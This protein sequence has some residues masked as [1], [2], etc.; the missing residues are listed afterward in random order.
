MKGLHK[1]IAWALALILAAPLP[2]GAQSAPPAQ[3]Q[4]QPPPFT[5]EQLD[6]LVAPIALYP[7]PLLAQVLMASTYPLEVVEAARWSKQNPSSTATR[8]RTPCRSRP[9]TPA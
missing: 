8:S 7:D 3:T 9:G 4:Q 5:A 2:I 6:Q 1:A